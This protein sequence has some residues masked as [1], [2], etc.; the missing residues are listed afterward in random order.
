MT[1][2]RPVNPNVEASAHVVFVH[3]LDGDPRKTWLSATEPKQFW[4]NWLN[5][6]LPE[7]DVWSLGYPATSIWWKRGAAMSLPDRAQ[8][9]LSELTSEPKIST[10]KIYFI[11]HSLGG[12]VV[13]SILRL[14]EARA[15]QDESA[16]SFVR[17]CR[18]IVFIGT[19]HAGS[20]QATL[21]NK[22]SLILRPRPTTMGL[23]S[24]DAHLRDL[25]SW[26][27]HYAVK[28]D[29]HVLVLRETKS[30]PLF[31]IPFLGGVIVKADSADP[32]LHPV[33]EVIPLDEDHLSI[34]APQNREAAVYRR[35]V[36]FLRKPALSQG[37]TLLADAAIDVGALVERRSDQLEAK[38]QEQSAT[39]LSAIA[40]MPRTIDGNEVASVARKRSYDVSEL[41]QLAE[42]LLSAGKPP[43]ISL[44]F[45]DAPSTGRDALNSLLKTERLVAE[46]KS[47]GSKA[48]RTSISALV[49]Q[50]ELKH[51][52]VGPPGSGKTSGLWEAARQALATDEVVPI[53]L[54]AG[55]NTTWAEIL[56]LI[57]T[58]APH[59]IPHEIFSDP[60]VCIFLDGWSEFATGTNVGERQKALREL[61][62]ARV[63]ANAKSVDA[64]DTA[65]KVWALE[66][67]Q[68][69]QVAQV[70]QQAYPGRA[71]PSQ[72][73]L[74]L[75]ELPLMLSI[76]VLADVDAFAVG[77]TLRQFHYH[78]ARGLPEAF[79]EVLLEAVAETSQDYERSFGRLSVCL[80][81]KAQVAGVHEP[82]KLLQ[83]LGTLGERGG[84]VIPIHDL[85]WNWL[86]GC[87]LLSGANG[88]STPIALH[89]RECYKLALQSGAR[90]RE[91]DVYAIL[92]DDIGLALALD[93]S[94]NPVR[95]SSILCESL[96][97]AM[98]DPRVAIRSRAAMAVIQIAEPQYLQ[99]SLHVLSETSHSWPYPAEWLKSIRPDLLFPYRSM[100]AEWMGASGSTMILD[101]I[102]ER[103]GTEWTSWLE[104]MALS[105]KISYV[106]A[107]ATAL[108][109]S[110]DVPAWGISH[111]D[112]LI[113]SKPWALRIVSQRK[114]N[115]NL[116]RLIANDYER[117]VEMVGTGSGW[118]DINRVLVACGD[119]AVFS[120]LLKSFSSM[121]KKAQELLGYAVVE[122]GSPWVALFQRIAFANPPE[123]SHHVLRG[124]VSL[125]IDDFSARQWI[126]N[127]NEEPGWRVLIARH[128]NAILPDLLAELPTSFGGIQ[129]VPALAYMGFL[130]NPP[131]S[132]IGELIQ[133]LAGPMQP[134]TTQDLFNALSRTFPLGMLAIVRL[135]VEQP[136]AW[137]A[138]HV[139]QVIGLYQ[140]WRNKGGNEIVVRQGANQ[141]A[142]FPHWMGTYCALR[143]WEGGSTALMLA[144][145]TDLAVSFVIEH[146][147]LD[148]DKTAE[149]LGH[150]RSVSAY[151]DVL[152]R[153]MIGAAVLAKLIPNVFSGCF[154]SFPCSALE[155]CIQ[156]PH[157]DQE[158][159][160][161]RL[162]ATSNPLHLTVHAELIQRALIH[163]TN[164]VNLK[165]IAAMLRGHSRHD[166]LNLL[167]AAPN[168]DEDSW[169][170][171]ARETELARDERLIDEAAQLLS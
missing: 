171:L 99:R 73:I 137:S 96:E 71:G 152:F 94:R 150:L 169:I 116:A 70:L 89:V 168:S 50:P 67:L 113:T 51:L 106:N 118:I 95:L 72:A 9:L 8:N 82:L 114:A 10:G 101:A 56:A 38:F 55:Q 156:S 3:G 129:N 102:A 120:V 61:H 64:S 35:L 4:P 60:R 100:I 159:L 140:D 25:N 92:N 127:G 58:A 145:A 18:K 166:V 105:G 85:Y 134:K 44:L 76:H 93:K 148:D 132:I 108:G 54:P 78:V 133:R 167:R 112:L 26:F 79:T 154:D 135:F 2:I 65:F 41:N 42:V 144:S 117:L 19:P 69:S 1:L 59:I 153:R 158:L 34:V 130:E 124:E 15:P 5:N 74:T 123:H 49:K 77:E 6:E 80:R 21:V 84:K 52:I 46:G 23:S 43:A 37:R 48:L 107:L 90:A 126:A 138:F 104:Q 164:R 13:K 163:P 98:N 36:E 45:P 161:Y 24:N 110:S 7:L 91:S 40:A 20:D 125:D 22:F 81:S 39:I 160:L 62:N 75:L 103:G 87:G 170:W 147:A 12:L 157:I 139:R 131:A 143:K 142:T 165:Y 83:K 115:I 119:N 122:L 121:G 136:N 109:C 29:L 149:I 27:R 16:A 97:R 63:I 111:M 57:T 32:G 28:N 162:G 66:L 151:I 33:N 128:G 47:A 30:S 141:A 17:R 155:E 146:L 14:A 68:P 86:V 53:Y 11:A 31:G 88:A